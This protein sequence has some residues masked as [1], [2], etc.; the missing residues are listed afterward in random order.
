MKGYI[1]NIVAG[2]G[3]GFIIEPQ[4]RIEYFFHRDDFNGHWN[5]LIDDY[6]NGLEQIPVEFSIVKSPRGPRASSVVRTDFPN[7]GT[8]ELDGNQSEI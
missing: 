2:K 7:Q 1:K 4:T 8:V 5:D 3:F 6:A